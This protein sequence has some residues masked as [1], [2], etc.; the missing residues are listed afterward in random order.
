MLPYYLG[1]QQP[2]IIVVVVVVVR[3][4]YYSRIFVC[5]LLNAFLSL[6]SPLSSLLLSP[7]LSQF[8]SQSFCSYKESTYSWTKHSVYHLRKL[9]WK[10]GFGLGKIIPRPYK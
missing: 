10:Q 5:F 2:G 1:F 7:P 9:E 3:K 8:L 4:L 6:F